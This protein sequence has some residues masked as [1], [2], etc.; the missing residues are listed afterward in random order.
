[1]SFSSLKSLF[2]RA[3]RRRREE[4][5]IIRK[6][7]DTLWKKN[8]KCWYVF[9]SMGCV[10]PDSVYLAAIGLLVFPREKRPNPRAP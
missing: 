7:I 9:F 1:M 8:R 2:Q 10:P 5:E 3:E 4:E 6:L